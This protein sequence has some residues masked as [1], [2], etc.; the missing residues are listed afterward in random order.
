VLAEKLHRVADNLY[1]AN[2]TNILYGIVKCRGK[3]IKQSLK[4]IDRTR[5]C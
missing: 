2:G 1:R 4:T 3:Q 5:A